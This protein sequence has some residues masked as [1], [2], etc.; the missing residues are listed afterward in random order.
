MR[1]HLS[2]FAE[3]TSDYCPDASVP[4]CCL[5][6]FNVVIYID[7]EECL[8]EVF[9]AGQIDEFVDASLCNDPA[10]D[11]YRYVI[12]KFFSYGEYVC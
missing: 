2:S 4:H 11:H 5:L 8:F 9:R 10:V 12:A 6:L 7:L 1:A 3:E